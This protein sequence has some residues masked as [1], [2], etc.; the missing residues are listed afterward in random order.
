VARNFNGTTAKVLM[1]LGAVPT[2][3]TAVSFAAIVNPTTVSRF[4]NICSM[5][6]SADALGCD[7]TISSGNVLQYEESGA[8]KNTVTSIGTGWQF[9]AV[10]KAAGASNVVD[11]TRYVYSNN[12]FTNTASSVVGNPAGTIARPYIGALGATDFFLGDI[13]IVAFWSRK[14]AATEVA[15]LPFSLQAWYTSAPT[16]AWLLDQAATGQK[17]RDFTGG[18]ANES[19]LTGTTVSTNSVPVFG[20]WDH[21]MLRTRSAAAAAAPELPRWPRVRFTG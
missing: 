8:A 20:Y 16:A 4:N 1:S 9:L 5:L 13:A 10:T 11:G 15:N 18:G 7:M 14:L 2:A 12:T 17:I 6:T 19:T 3:I 21:Q